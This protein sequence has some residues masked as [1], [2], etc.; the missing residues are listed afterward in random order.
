MRCSL[1][2]LNSPNKIS[3][4]N[5][6]LA[7][8]NKNSTANDES[9]VVKANV[10]TLSGRIEKMA[11]YHDASYNLRNT[12]LG[13]QIDSWGYFP[14][15]YTGL[16]AVKFN[17][18][19]Y[20]LYDKH[21]CTIQAS[22]LF[23]VEE[24][25]L[26][27]SSHH[28][29]P[30]SSIPELSSTRSIVEKLRLLSR[31]I[32][33]ERL[34]LPVGDNINSKIN[35]LANEK[36]KLEKNLTRLCCQMID[37]FKE[38][39]QYENEENSNLRTKY[40]NGYYLEVAKAVN[41]SRILENTEKIA[42]QKEA[43]DKL[44]NNLK[45][46]LFINIEKCELKIKSLLHIER[47]ATRLKHLTEA[48]KAKME[49]QKQGKQYGWVTT[50]KL[51]DTMLFHAT[52]LESHDEPTDMETIYGE[53]VR[54]AD[55]EKY[56]SIQTE[57]ARA[58]WA[59]ELWNRNKKIEATNNWRIAI[60]NSKQ[61]DNGSDITRA[62]CSQMYMNYCTAY[63]NNEIHNKTLKELFNEWNAYVETWDKESATY[64]KEKGNIYSLSL[65][66]LNRGKDESYNEGRNIIED[67]CYHYNQL[68]EIEDKCSAD[69]IRNIIYLGNN[70]GAY[71]IDYSE[72]NNSY[73]NLAKMYLASVYEICIRYYSKEP[74][75]A[76]YWLSQNHHNFGF[77]ADNVSDT[78]AAQE[79]YH[80][81][82][83]YCQ[84][85]F[86]NT[87]RDERRA[88]TL[89]NLGECYRRQKDYSKAEKCAKESIDIYQT[90]VHRNG[91]NSY[92]CMNLYK[93]KQLLG[94]I[95]QRIPEKREKGTLLLKECREWAINNQDCSYIK[96]F[97][98][99]SF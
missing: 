83:Y 32:E 79:H 56:F 23:T 45:E 71:Y 12:A 17:I 26:Y 85:I 22:N 21:K 40:D 68:K 10:E 20:M 6:Y 95:Y 89:V 7:I 11:I 19:C 31:R 81:S 16:D 37:I 46:Q 50:E 75:D 2:P 38:Q 73:H 44:N 60:D 28:I 61:F 88:E 9:E 5:Y 99:Y 36:N 13:K 78:K 96:I 69:E 43:V 52:L 70:I 87:M 64:L 15:T 63:T 72:Y 55:K 42:T 77:L 30:I 33:E 41:T 48:V 94:T 62:T 82:L 8:L 14:I 1:H 90:F 51:I 35:N 86:D 58:N 76:V 18:L 54:L 57:L 3:D 98:K 24:C 93:A 65:K 27:F 92:D 97:K 53:I 91:E 4:T 80:K 34:L 25:A 66:A 47:N 29:A 84:Y 39:L 59:N 49:L 67:A 74:Q